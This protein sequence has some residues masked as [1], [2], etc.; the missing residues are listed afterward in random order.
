MPALTAAGPLLSW[1][2]LF[3]VEGG[4]AA[5]DDSGVTEDGVAAEAII[6]G[7]PVPTGL[8]EP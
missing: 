5:K 3:R 1:M 7:F 4:P 2:S 6:L 8:A